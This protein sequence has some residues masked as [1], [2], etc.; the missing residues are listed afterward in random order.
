MQA[1]GCSSLNHAII[2]VL[3]QVQIAKLGFLPCSWYGCL[4]PQHPFVQLQLLSMCLSHRGAAWD[5]CSF[6]DLQR[7]PISG[8]RQRLLAGKSFLH[9]VKTGFTPYVIMIIP[10]EE[11]LA[12]Y[13]DPL[14][15]PLCLCR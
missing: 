10:P 5:G 1:L 14:G 15:V 8:P 3:F 4:Q 13:K 7:T 6:A 12:D 11:G 2:F 9:S